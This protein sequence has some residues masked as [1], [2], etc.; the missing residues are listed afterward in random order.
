MIMKSVKKLKRC[1]GSSY[2]FEKYFSDNEIRSIYKNKLHYDYD[3][4]IASL[5]INH[6]RLDTVFYWNEDGLNISF[7]VY[8]KDSIDSFEWICFDNVTVAHNFKLKNLEK[9]MVSFLNR[10]IDCYHLSYSDCYYETVIPKED[11]K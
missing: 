6:I 2:H 10:E 11:K 4:K 3:L 1:F 7:D 9:E 5:K 8:V